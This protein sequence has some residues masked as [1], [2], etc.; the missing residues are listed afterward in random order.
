M[1]EAIDILVGVLVQ[2][3]V[4]VS[5]VHQHFSLWRGGGAF[6]KMESAGVIH[7]KWASN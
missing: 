2:L 7:G 6:L 4:E 1:G 5:E 3:V